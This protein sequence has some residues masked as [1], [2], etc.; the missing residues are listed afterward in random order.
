[1][2]HILH[3]VSAVNARVARMKQFDADRLA[4]RLES[5]IV[6]SVKMNHGVNYELIGKEKINDKTKQ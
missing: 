3:S 1:M 6:E 4:K 2:R 5:V